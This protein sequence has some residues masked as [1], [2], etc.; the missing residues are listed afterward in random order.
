M[1][2]QVRECLIERTLWCH[3]ECLHCQL[4]RVLALRLLID[5]YDDRVDLCPR[6]EGLRSDKADSQIGDLT[7]DHS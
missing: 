3:V 2:D 4:A 6:Q 5:P 7:V 1:V